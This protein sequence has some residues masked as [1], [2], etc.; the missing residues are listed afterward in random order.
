MFT[1]TSLYTNSL[2]LQN[3]LEY[4]I[5]SHNKFYLFH[6]I[7]FI[8]LGAFAI[9]APIF[10]TKGFV[11]VVGVL[12]FFSGVIKAISYC[13]MRGYWLSCLA[14]MVSVAFGYLLIISPNIGMYFLSLIIGLF[15]LV[16]GTAQT[17][18]AINLRSIMEY[19][20]LIFSG[21]I[22]AILGAII[23]FGMPENGAIFFGIMV[24]ISF[25]LYGISIFT[26]VIKLSKY[27]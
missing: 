19:K 20:M 10:V 6:S 11:V 25:I 2:E 22:S 16:E 7:I 4:D 27:F 9:I 5:I 26:M 21:I 23:L 18:F 8:L 13:I 14:S 3:D 1:F 12:L 17:V 24:G 15:L